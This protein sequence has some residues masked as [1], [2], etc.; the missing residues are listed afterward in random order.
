MRLV[1]MNDLL[2][3]CSAPEYADDIRRA[4]EQRKPPRLSQPALEVLAIVAY[5]Q[6]VTRAYIDQVRTMG[7]QSLDELPV[8][9]DL[10]SDEG[11]EK[12]EQ[13]ISELR[14]RGK[15]MELTDTEQKPT[16]E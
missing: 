3:L 8:L 7:M 10:S 9:P 1:Q 14:G 6:P 16:G 4:L 11:A 15:Q 13:A 12:L 5:F 2:Q